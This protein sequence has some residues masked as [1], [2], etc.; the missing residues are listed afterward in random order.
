[1]EKLTHWKK[2]RDTNY[3]GCWDL[4]DG[5]E[6]KAIV[7]TISAVKQEKVLNLETNA[8]TDEIVLHFAEKQYKP[9]IL[10]TTNKQAIEKATGTPFIEQW[11]GNKIKIN[12]E[13]VKAFGDMHDALRISPIPVKIEMAKCE[14]CGKEIQKRIYDYTKQECGFGVCSKECRDKMTAKKEEA[15]E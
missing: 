12:V 6:Y 10:N 1:M 15:N 7:L 13:K 9:M 5:E 8:K 11:A 2:T 14:C 3:L 4:L